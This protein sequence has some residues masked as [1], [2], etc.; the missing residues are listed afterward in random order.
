MMHAVME[1]TDCFFHTHLPA[2]HPGHCEQQNRGSMGDLSFWG[3]ED[4]DHSGD[5]SSGAAATPAVQV[6]AVNLLKGS[7]RGDPA[8]RPLRILAD[9][10]TC[11]Q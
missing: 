9:F 3:F 11:T 6:P 1:Q 7:I 2:H 10:V 5:S 8:R 4:D